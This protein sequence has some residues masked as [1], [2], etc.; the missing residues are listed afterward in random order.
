MDE[1]NL[2]D[3]LQYFISQ[4]A[5]KVIFKNPPEGTRQQYPNPN[6]TSSVDNARAVGVNAIATSVGSKF[7]TEKS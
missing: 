3:C 2:E 7:P 4:S 1:G 6:T 5:R